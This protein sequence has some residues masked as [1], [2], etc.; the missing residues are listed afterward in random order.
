MVRSADWHH[1][2]QIHRLVREG[3]NLRLLD[4][5]RTR[6]GLL[7]WVSRNVHAIP[8]V[9]RED[10]FHVGHYSLRL[11]RA[12]HQWQ[13]SVQVLKLVTT[14]ANGDDSPGRVRLT[15]SGGSPRRPPAIVHRLFR[16]GN[17]EARDRFA[18]SANADWMYYWRQRTQED[19]DEWR[20]YTKPS[21]K[22][23]K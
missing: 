9:D 1:G 11:A 4:F 20:F 23:L 22:N 17:P 3:K 13:N 6:R 18:L 12:G 10:E 21:S 15:A 8:E 5:L 7:L 2:R 14:M 19:R 16:R